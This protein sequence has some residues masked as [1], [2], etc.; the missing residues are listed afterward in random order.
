MCYG[1]LMAQV[2][3]QGITEI[4]FQLYQAHLAGYIF[5]LGGK[6]GI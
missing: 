4:E 3:E 1:A 6:I 2:F 5:G